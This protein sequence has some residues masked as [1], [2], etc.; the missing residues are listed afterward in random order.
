MWDDFFLQLSRSNETSDEPGI[1]RFDIRYNDERE[2][3]EELQRHRIFSQISKRDL[4]PPEGIGIVLFE[5]V[6]FS[7]HLLDSRPSGRTANKN[8][9]N[10]AQDTIATRAISENTGSGKCHG[11]ELP[12]CDSSSPSPDEA[13]M[14]RGDAARSLPMQRKRKRASSTHTRSSSVTLLNQRERSHKQPVTTATL[15]SD[16]ATVPGLVSVESLILGALRLSIY[17]SL[18]SRSSCGLKIKANT[19]HLGL[20]DIAPALWRPGYLLV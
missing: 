8:S 19:F 10:A 17:G 13:Y 2:P 16:K 1:T 12:N 20:A 18:S 11:S 3:Q 6:H 9:K 15:V 5:F 4:K 7:M 14:F